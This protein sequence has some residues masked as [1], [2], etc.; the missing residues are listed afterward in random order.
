MN[1]WREGG[2]EGVHL[3]ENELSSIG[4]YITSCFLWGLCV[5]LGKGLVCWWEEDEEDLVRFNSFF[6]FF[7]FKSRLSSL[8]SK[9]LRVQQVR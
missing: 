9:G 8:S 4:H 3:I 2:R 6:V 7:A 1:E 5:G